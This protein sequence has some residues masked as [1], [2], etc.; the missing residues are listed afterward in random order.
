MK[1]SGP[2]DAT[3]SKILTRG[4]TTSSQPSPK[5]RAPAK[6]KP[7]PIQVHRP[8]VP[9]KPKPGSAR[10]ARPSPESSS[11]FAQ[12]IRNSGPAS[13][14]LTA[15]S[16]G[17]RRSS[18]TT[19]LSKKP[20]SR[21]ESAFS[22]STRGPRL[23]ARSAAG[24]KA[25]GNSTSDLIDFIREGPPTAGAR[26]IPRTVAPFRN[27]MDSDDM[28]YQHSAPSITSTQGESSATKSQA[29]VGSRTGLLDSSKGTN[30]KSRT[31]PTKPQSN[32]SSRTVTEE[33]PRPKRTQRRVPD[34]YALDWD[35]DELEELLEEEAKPKREESLIDFLRNVPPPESEPQ[36]LAVNKPSKTTSSSFGGAS[37]M[38][39]RL[40]R[41]S[42]SDKAPPPRVPSSKPSQSSLRQQ[43][44]QNPT[45]PS[46]YTTKSSSERNTDSMYGLPS[47]SERQTE[48]SALADFLRNTGPP[49]PPRPPPSKDSSFSRRFFTRRKKVEA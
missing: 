9:Q 27:T 46:N 43:S 41:S 30:S 37:S 33:D 25:E 23:Q 28:A 7:A 12:F 6:S 31:V 3:R 39:S 4:A 18:D 34:P 8:V 45:R 13:P 2:E 11:D 22:N 24:P 16:P 48:T 38:K 20:P 36:P 44:D 40:L 47:V 15:K 26:R 10:D 19:E 32:S 21:P 29:S 14:P 35:D 5:S 42:P 1:S 49:E 17:A